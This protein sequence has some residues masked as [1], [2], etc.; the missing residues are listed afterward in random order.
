MLRYVHPDTFKMFETEAPKMGFRN[1]AAGPDG[2]LRAT[3]PTSG[4]RAVGSEKTFRGW[5]GDGFAL[6]QVGPGRQPR[7]WR[8]PGVSL[9]RGV[10]A[11]PAPGLA[12]P[13]LSRL[14]SGLGAGVA[15]RLH[16]R[17]LASLGGCLGGGRRGGGDT[18]L[19]A[20]LTSGHAVALFPRD[21]LPP[22]RS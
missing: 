19:V 10:A 16:S 3:G 17:P 5:P 2:A 8:G 7:G 4:A 13:G 22:R 14:W 1:A 6:T 18:K 12:A 9:P 11:S 21:A 15:R 20:A